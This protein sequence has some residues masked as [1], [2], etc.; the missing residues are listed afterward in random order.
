MNHRNNEY[1]GKIETPHAKVTTNAAEGFF[2]Q[3]KRS[4]DGT[5]HH[6]SSQHLDR[7][8]AEFD[9]KYNA[10]KMKDSERMGLAVRKAA[11][12]RLMYEKIV[13]Q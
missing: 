12:K 6:V 1:V 13:Q 8:L 2:S 5:H 4:I 9:Y 3:L 10:R 7:Y 11:G